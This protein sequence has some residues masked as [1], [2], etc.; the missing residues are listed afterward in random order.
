MSQHYPNVTYYSTLWFFTTSQSCLKLFPEKTVQTFRQQ[1]E[2][3]HDKHALYQNWSL[4]QGG[5]ALHSCVLKRTKKTKK[6][7]RNCLWMLNCR[8]KIL[9]SLVNAFGIIKYNNGLNTEPIPP[10]PENHS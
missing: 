6:N 8:I 3:H 7:K 1:N 4:P 10:E 5:Q 2:E 9:I